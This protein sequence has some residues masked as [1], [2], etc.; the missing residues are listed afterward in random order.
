M[1]LHKI[2]KGLDLP[3]TGAPEAKIDDGNSAVRH[4]ALVAADYVGMK[5][6]MHVAVGDGVKRGQLVFEDKKIPGVRFT[7]PGAGKVVAIHRG[8]R[9]AF[10]SMVIELDDLDQAGKGEQIVFETYTAKPIPSLSR[11]EIEALLVESGMWTA[12]RTRPFSKTPALGSTPH[13]IFVTA[14]DSNPLAPN[15]AT[16]VKGKEK[17]FEAGLLCIAKLTDG[18]VYL[19]RAPGTAITAPANSNVVVEEFQGVHPAGT[20]GVHIHTLA[21]VHRDKTVWH[22]GYQDVIAV[23]A[24]FSTGQLDLDR[25]IALAGPAVKQP[26]LIRTRLGASTDDLTEGQLNDGENRVISGSILSGTA[27]SGEVH[28]YLGRF[29]NQ[30]SVIC[31]DRERVFLGWL[32][33]GFKQFSII[34][35]FASCLT[36]GKKF[37]FTTSQNGGR[38]A[39][40]PI[41]MYEKVMPMDI[42]PTFLLRA[43]IMDDLERA[44]LLGCLELD[45]EDL[46]LCTFV[47]P[48]KYDYGP[49]LRR[50]LTTIEK[51]G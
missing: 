43:L 11:D 7:A 4:V 41:G 19:C 3:I 23:G 33:P 36:P 16:I 47:C 6:R 46:A 27:A 9:R 32:G 25:V 12:L 1:A 17:E 30:I 51:E 5:P 28:G 42:L 35:A 21:P 14:T 15:P 24:L 44:E 8:E 2:A 26:R 34:R 50:N 20:V 29:H 40:V 37:N 31:E 22:I 48:G 45:E 13:S 10:Q 49:I 39:M 18:K 38:R